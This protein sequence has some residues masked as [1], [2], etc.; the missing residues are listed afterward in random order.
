M[1]KLAIIN[2]ALSET[3]NDTI[4]TLYDGSDEWRVADIG[5]ERGLKLV[6]SMHQW[7]FATGF[8]ECQREGDSPDL[9]YTD[10]Y[11]IPQNILHLRGL[12]DGN[13]CPIGS[14]KLSRGLILLTFPGVTTTNTVLKAE[15]VRVPDDDANWHPM[16]EEVL[17]LKTEASIL[18]GLNEDFAEAVLRDQKVDTMLLRAQVRTDQQTP[19]RRGFYPSMS[20]TRRTRRV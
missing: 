1:N 9:S 14:Y 17:T 12:Q 7:P 18:R 5:F 13:G 15:V 2:N 4:E 3:G 10:A 16:A 20:V 6:L 11:A 19:P 8:E